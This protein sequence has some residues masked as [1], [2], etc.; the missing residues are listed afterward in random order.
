MMQKL[1]WSEDG[2]LLLSLR[3]GSND[4]HI[5]GQ[6]FFV[7]LAAYK[8]RFIYYVNNL[9][10]SGGWWDSFDLARS[11]LVRVLTD[12]VMCVLPVYK[13]PGR[14]KP[15]KIKYNEEKLFWSEDGLLMLSTREGT[16]TASVIGQIYQRS[17]TDHYHY[18]YY[19]NKLG[20]TG[21][22]WDSSDE[23]RVD[24][25][26][27]LANQMNRGIPVY[28]GLSLKPI[29][30]NTIEEKMQESTKDKLSL[31]DVV[32]LKSGSPDM[33]I[34]SITTNA[35]GET[36]TAIRYEYGMMATLTDLPVACLKK[37][38]S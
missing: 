36:Y 14:I 35:H 10:L 7:D 30:V 4:A 29:E 21:G 26:Q 9:C 25:V 17:Y 31:G 5:V 8:W 32:Q 12:K 3:E 23:T 28:G 38:K 24:L 27:A 15:T 16:D 13:G 34:K 20:V 1:F 37:V 33:T 11:A 19:L 22:W 2:S 18:S 6:I